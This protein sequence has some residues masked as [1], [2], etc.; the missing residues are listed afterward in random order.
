[1]RRFRD[2]QEEQSGTIRRDP[3][4]VRGRRD[5]QRTGEA[6]WSAPAM[7]RQAVASFIPPAR[8][9]H[10]RE[11]PKL[12]PVKEAID[13]MLEQDRQA[14]RKQRHTAH[15]VWTRLREEDPDHPIG[16][17]TVRRY[18]RQRKQEMGLGRREVFVPQ[19]YDWGQEGQVDWFEAM[20]KLD[21]KLCKLQL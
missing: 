13:R 2:E 21:G 18:V 15:R 8:K 19:S 16:E 11:Q 4:G 14:P 17:P 6:A 9:K 20:A 10:E 1:M 7:V 5:D 3:V 12:D